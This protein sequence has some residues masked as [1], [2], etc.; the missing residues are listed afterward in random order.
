[1]S[2]S[3]RRSERRDAREERAKSLTVIFRL[4]WHY[5]VERRELKF[6]TLIQSNTALDNSETFLQAGKLLLNLLLLLLQVAFCRAGDSEP[7]LLFLDELG[8]MGFGQEIIFKWLM[9]S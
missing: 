5:L 7:S 3:S 1:L 6:S 4:L 8:V 9:S 2:T